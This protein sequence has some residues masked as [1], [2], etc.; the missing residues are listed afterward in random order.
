MAS[1][2]GR[3]AE[4]PLAVKIGVPVAIGAATAAGIAYYCLKKKDPTDRKIKDDKT[5]KK[6]PGNSKERHRNAA[7]SSKVKSSDTGKE[8]K[9]KA[10]SVEEVPKSDLE[11]ARDWKIRGNKWFGA[12][13]YAKALEYYKK[14]LELCPAEHTKDRAI[15]NQNI[16]AAYERLA[17]NDQLTNEE[18][19]EISELVIQHCSE[20]LSL[21]KAYAKA[22]ARRA[23][24]YRIVG[25]LEK[26]L[27]DYVAATVLDDGV[28]KM[29]MTDFQQLLAAYTEKLIDEE[30]KSRSWP[31]SSSSSLP[32]NLSPAAVDNI[33][34]EAT[35]L[36]CFSKEALQEMWVAEK[37]ES[38]SDEEPQ[39][40]FE[41]EPMCKAVTAFLDHKYAEV[42]ALFDVAATDGAEVLKPYARLAKGIT[43]QLWHQNKLALEELEATILLPNATKDVR[44]YCH[45]IKSEVLHDEGM[46]EEALSQY[47]LA[48]KEDGGNPDIY[49][50]R[51]KA[52]LTDEKSLNPLQGLEDVKEAHKLDPNNPIMV[53]TLGYTTFKVGAITNSMQMIEEATKLLNEA[54][55]KFPNNP[56]VFS[57]FG[58]MLQESMQTEKALE[59]FEK[60]SELKPDDPMNLVS[61]CFSLL[62]SGRS[63]EEASECAKL[64]LEKDP[65]YTLAYQALASLEMQKVNTDKAL[66]LYR[67]AIQ[68]TLSK[69]E[70]AQVLA[71]YSVTE[72][73]IQVCKDLGLDLAQVLAKAESS[74]KQGLGSQA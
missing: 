67:K 50:F 62:F 16:A 26:S 3:F 64:A 24:A 13:N 5:L 45:L 41:D 33:L 56:F 52:R 7:E 17:N 1:G 19:K 58:H 32:D 9:D 18:K 38:E 49:L 6:P 14:A 21:D 35:R 42:V 28:G 51:G 43:L 72:V 66:E 74:L 61:K 48:L 54:T 2:E 25:F 68:C 47:G 57:T 8:Y 70:L 39:K 69:N 10:E 31:P 71:V 65:Y 37:E 30:L 27:Y 29:V 55:K 36:K 46:S 60:A 73:Q 12:E 15:F 59:C 53:A 40:R 11:K 63:I 44:L 22:F 4:I 23:R 34:L 20:A